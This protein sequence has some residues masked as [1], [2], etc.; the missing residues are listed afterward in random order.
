MPARVTFADT[1]T[2]KNDWLPEVARARDD[3]RVRGILIWARF[4]VW[5]TRQV[6]GGVEVRLRDMRFRGIGRGGFTASTIVP[7]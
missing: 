5:D 2:L 1:A 7:H 3:R 4:P 6:P